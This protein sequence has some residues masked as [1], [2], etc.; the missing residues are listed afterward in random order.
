[1][2]IRVDPARSEPSERRKDGEADFPL[3]GERG[4]SALSPLKETMSIPGEGGA[5]AEASSRTA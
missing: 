2:R 4:Q 5:A 1:M 3:A